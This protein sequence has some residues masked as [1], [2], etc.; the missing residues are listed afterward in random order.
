MKSAAF[1]LGLVSLSAAFTPQPR[2]SLGARAVCGTTL[3][4]A[5]ASVKDVTDDASDRMAKSVDSVR[6]NLQSVRTGRAS[7]QILDRVKVDYYGVETPLNQMATISVPS[8]QQLSIDPY[9]KTS[10]NN[11]ETAIVE[12]DLGLTTNNDGSI[13]RINIPS[14]TEDRRKE[15]LKLCK[16]IGEEGKVA[17]RN[18]RRDGLDTIKKMEKSSDIGEDEMKDGQDTMQKLTDKN[19]KEIDEVVGAKEKEVMKV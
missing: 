12:S 15:M 5:V 13:I 19:V 3:Y 1:L 11:I 4:A 18:I 2:I 16:S 7:A 6:L 9:D 8:A 14:M 10:L 17:V